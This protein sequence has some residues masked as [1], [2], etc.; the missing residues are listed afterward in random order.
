M[1]HR[2]HR[3]VEAFRIEV[4]E[5][6]VCRVVGYPHETMTFTTQDMGRF[7]TRFLETVNSEGDDGED[8]SVW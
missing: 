5:E 4:D 6:G 8:D 2:D 3:P 7:L 1:R